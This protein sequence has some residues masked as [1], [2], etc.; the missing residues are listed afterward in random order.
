MRR[1][2]E[3]TTHIRH[4]YGFVPRIS[5]IADVLSEHGLVAGAAPVR[6]G[7]QVRRH[8]CP[9]ERRQAIVAA[10]RHFGMI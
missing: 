1:Y 8:P 5:W 10:L 9:P 6:I 4:K 2:R 3:I 7:V